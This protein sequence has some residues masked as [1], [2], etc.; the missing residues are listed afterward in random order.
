[1]GTV[2]GILIY[3]GGDYDGLWDPECDDIGYIDN[4]LNRLTMRTLGILL[5]DEWMD[6]CD[7]KPDGSYGFF[8]LD[9]VAQLPVSKCTPVMAVEETAT[10]VQMQQDSWGTS[11]SAA[12]ID[13]RPVMNFLGAPV[14]GGPTEMEDSRILDFQECPGADIDPRPVMDF[15]GPSVVGGPR[16]WRLEHFDW[17]GV[18]PVSV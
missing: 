3:Y 16:R 17:W 2:D 14:V 9:G 12:D 11:V 15:L 10:P 18:M 1:M 7:F 13:P 8:P 4:F 6:W 5:H